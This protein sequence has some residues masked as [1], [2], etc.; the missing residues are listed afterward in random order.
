MLDKIIKF[1]IQTA[2]GTFVLTLRS[3]TGRLQKVL[4]FFVKV[5]YPSGK[6]SP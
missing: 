2:V 6:N 3:L 1:P 4:L 5:G